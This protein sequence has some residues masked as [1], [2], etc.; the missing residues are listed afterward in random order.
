MPEL[1]ARV[2]MKAGDLEA[3]IDQRRDVLRHALEHV[4]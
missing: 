1:A 2:S 4:S 3:E